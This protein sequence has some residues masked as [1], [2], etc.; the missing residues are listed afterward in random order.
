[1]INLYH[2]YLYYKIHKLFI[3]VAVRDLVT[4]IKGLNI[5]S[6]KDMVVNMLVLYLI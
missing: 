6:D 2:L 3:K 5:G 4:K 1:M